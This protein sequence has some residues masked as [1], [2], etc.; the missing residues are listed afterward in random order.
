[1]V[2][3]N[4]R[5]VTNKTVCLPP[6][7]AICLMYGAEVASFFLNTSISAPHLHLVHVYCTT[8]D[9]ENLALLLGNRRSEQLACMAALHEGRAMEQPVVG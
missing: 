4:C 7:P 3:D 2:G 1:M 5:D 9:V 8:S 6:P